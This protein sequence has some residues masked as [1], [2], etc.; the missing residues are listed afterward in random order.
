MP[1]ETTA[2]GQLLSS[3]GAERCVIGSILIDGDSILAIADI[4][5]PEH[6]HG[7]DTRHVFAA[8]T[9]LL[10][11]GVHIDQQTL[12]ARLEGNGH[13]EEIGGDSFLSSAVSEV[14]H[15]QN[16]KFYANEVKRMFIMRQ[17]ALGGEQAMSIGSDP[18]RALDP[19]AA[20]REVEDIIFEIGANTTSPDFVAIRHARSI[21]T[22]FG[23]TRSG[24]TD[25]DGGEPIPTGLDALDEQLGGL[26][27]SD[28][29]VLAARPGIGKS[30]LALNCALNAAKQGYKVGIFSLEMGIDQIVHRMAASHCKL[31][32][33][34]IRRDE[35]SQSEEHRLSDAYGYFEDINIYVD[36]SAI[37]TVAAMRSKARRL[38]MI[39]G[40]DFLIVDYMQ[41]IS[42][43]SS[44]RDGNRVQEVSEISRNLKAIARDLE[45]PVLACSQ[46]NRQVE[47]RKSQEPKLSDLRESGSIE[48]DADI[49]MFIHRIDKNMSENDWNRRNPT[50]TY[51]K[52]LADIL[53]AKHRH[54]P[55]G[56]VQM[57]VRDEWGLFSSIPSV[58]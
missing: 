15:A 47:H 34:A 51:P 1:E 21:T 57:A 29:I 9:E 42:G 55:T 52:G 54:G 45:V 8:C 58:E 46:L 5:S 37:Q 19:D 17:I 4:L 41:L 18:T 2:T 13:L 23:D 56:E 27:R 28:L 3:R 22:F 7:E 44:G 25:V 14:P 10:I 53:I 6:F 30:T 12:R 16:I 20:I 24:S 11:E 33:S 48:Q 38:K 31:D 26:H 32:I 40:L 43:S 49:V 50:Q 39:S 36:D 35:L